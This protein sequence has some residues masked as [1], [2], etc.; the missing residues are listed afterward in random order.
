MNSF[1]VLAGSGQSV[2]VV[3]SEYSV[4]HPW[5]RSGREAVGSGHEGQS[6]PVG[7]NNPIRPSGCMPV[8]MVQAPKHR[9]TNDPACWVGLGRRSRSA[10]GPLAQ[11]PLGTPRI[12]VGDVFVQDALAFTPSTSESD[13]W[14]NSYVYSYVEEARRH[15]P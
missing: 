9:P 10:R 8:H 5:Y 14:H 12:E 3:M 13:V 1:R 6:L 2:P 11:P 15:G 7:R 4:G